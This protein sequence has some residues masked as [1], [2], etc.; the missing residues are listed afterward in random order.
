MFEFNESEL[1]PDG[2]RHCE[3]CGARI[4]PIEDDDSY[5][6]DCLEEMEEESEEA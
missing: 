6:V 1:H 5:C 3:E 2:Y 4:D